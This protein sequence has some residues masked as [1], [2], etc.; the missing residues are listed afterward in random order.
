MSNQYTVSLSVVSLT[1]LTIQIIF[2][3]VDSTSAQGAHSGNICKLTQSLL[4]EPRSLLKFEGNLF[5]IEKNPTASRLKSFP[6]FSRCLVFEGIIFKDGP[7]GSKVFSEPVIKD[8]IALSAQDVEDACLFGCVRLLY[9]LEKRGSKP[10]HIL[11]VTSAEYLTCS[12]ARLDSMTAVRT[13]C[14]RLQQGTLPADF[15]PESGATDEANATISRAFLMAK[16]ESKH[17]RKQ[18]HRQRPLTRFIN[19][20]V[21]IEDLIGFPNDRI[22]LDEKASSL[23]E[24]QDVCNLIFQMV[25]FRYN[26]ILSGSKVALNVK[27][28]V[29]EVLRRNLTL[30]I[31]CLMP[32]G[33]SHP[34]QTTEKTRSKF[35]CILGCQRRNYV[36]RDTGIVVQFAFNSGCIPIFFT[37]CSKACGSTASAARIPIPVVLE[38][39]NEKD[40]R[41]AI[42][43]TAIMTL[44]QDRGFSDLNEDQI[45]KVVTE[46]VGNKVYKVVVWLELGGSEF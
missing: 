17:E 15:F 43:R 19:K 21:C 10:V 11:V 26:L 20:D 7:P 13:S 28:S 1:L 38:V 46:R 12:K 34:I 29:G 44:R 39:K 32:I 24:K 27:D 14:K 23:F 22:P 2:C 6:S 4:Y 31:Q 33:S 37:P 41:K 42:V 40:D 16:H 5:L 36:L 9:R 35:H 3:E 30:P 25:K 8:P 18:N 45:F